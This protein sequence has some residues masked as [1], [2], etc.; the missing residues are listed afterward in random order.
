MARALGTNAGEGWLYVS[1]CRVCVCLSLHY[2]HYAAVAIDY[3]SN[4]V[5]QRHTLL[6]VYLYWV[7]LKKKLT[8]A[9]LFPSY[10][11]VCFN[12]NVSTDLFQ[13]NKKVSTSYFKGMYILFRVYLLPK[14]I[15]VYVLC[16]ELLINVMLCILLLS[17]PYLETYTKVET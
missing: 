7:C 17:G 8:L 13:I 9:L 4:I 6:L 14:P 15:H 1:V 11:P 16:F 12:K 3:K 2:M 10:N 5:Y